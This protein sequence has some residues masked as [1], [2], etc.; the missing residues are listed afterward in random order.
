MEQEEGDASPT[1]TIPL[2]EAR[3]ITSVNGVS[4]LRAHVYKHEGKWLYSLI[5]LH[6]G[7]READ[8]VE[9]GEWDERSRIREVSRMRKE[10]EVVGGM[11]VYIAV[12]C[13]RWDC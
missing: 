7:A 8:M 6:S 9:E 2:E 5:S 4:Y 12:G 10:D 13:A 3:V 1:L 11:G